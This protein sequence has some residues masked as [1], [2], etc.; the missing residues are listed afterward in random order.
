ML[1][2]LFTWIEIVHSKTKNTQKSNEEIKL[3]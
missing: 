2:F 1:D 3:K